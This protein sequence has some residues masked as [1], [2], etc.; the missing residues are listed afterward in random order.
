MQERWI[1]GVKAGDEASFAALY[2]CYATD[3]LRHLAAMLGDRQ[4]AEEVLHEVMM[5]MIQKIHHYAPRPEMKNP[6][7]AWLYRMATHRAIDEIRRKKGQAALGWQD[8]A[9]ETA[10]A[11]DER[12]L[13][14]EEGQLVGELLARLPLMQ[15]TVLGLRVHDEL[16]Y[17]EI[18]SVVGRD[19]NA[20]K[21]SLFHAKK[22]LK[23][24]WL[25]REGVL[26]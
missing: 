24:M 10:V 13:R 16:S 1:E 5:L 14:L 23:D 11:G 19:V 21:Q 18:A 12:L 7:K 26:A 25:A 22:G 3:L 6:F 15:R 2:H 17:L 8:E 4:E 9:A 20:V